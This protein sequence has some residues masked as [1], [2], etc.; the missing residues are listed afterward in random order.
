MVRGNSFEPSSERCLIHHVQEPK[1]TLTVSAQRSPAFEKLAERMREGNVAQ[2]KR[3]TVH[4]QK[5][6]I[7]KVKQ[8][9]QAI[10]DRIEQV[11][12]KVI[13]GCTPWEMHDI[14]DQ[15]SQQSQE[16]WHLAANN[17]LL[18][19]R[20]TNHL[21]QLA[22]QRLQQDLAEQK[23]ILQQRLNDINEQIKEEK[24][25]AGDEMGL[26]SSKMED[27]SAG[28]DEDTT[29]VY[30]DIDRGKDHHQE[31]IL[32]SNLSL[33]TQDVKSS[34]ED[35]DDLAIDDEVK[36]DQQMPETDESDEAE[37]EVEDLMEIEDLENGGY[38]SMEE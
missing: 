32:P 12:A 30:R 11:P 22:T 15:K 34:V 6:K 26:I 9:Q 4:H 5:S 7:L 17:L 2:V 36:S 28:T 1:T 25:L 18:L 31:V 27:S 21:L 10:I 38:Y 29:L 13:T 14:R 8:R 19:E 24:N 3:N 37:E 35:S 16:M 23:E 20:S 33:V